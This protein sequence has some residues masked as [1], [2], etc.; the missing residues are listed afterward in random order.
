[1]ISDI[2]SSQG[3]ER[4]HQLILRNIQSIIDPVL[5][6]H[7]LSPLE[8]RERKDLVIELMKHPHALESTK[9]ANEKLLAQ[10]ESME[11][12]MHEIKRVLDEH[13]V[14]RRPTN[15]HFP[16]SKYFD[17][18]FV[19][20]LTD[21]SGEMNDVNAAA[22]RDALFHL[23]DSEKTTH[24]STQKPKIF[25]I[26]FDSGIL[27]IA[28]ANRLTFDW[29]ER[30]VTTVNFHGRWPNAKFN[31]EFVAVKNVIPP[32]GLKT[33]FAK[34]SD[35]QFRHFNYLMK[36]LL[37]DNPN[38]LTGRWELRGLRGIDMDSPNAMYVGVDVES[39]ISLEE[40]NRIAVVG[41]SIVSFHIC[42]DENEEH[43]ELIPRKR[44]I[45]KICF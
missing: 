42:Y 2:R 33:I 20:H 18:P 17:I 11:K 19:V 25:D 28:C 29:I 10:K 16:K 37:L 34:F 35:P 30:T 38:L 3:N 1:M 9:V 12:V 6:P 31:V 4:N 27:V 8:E 22:L 39:L 13:I 45:N 40:N 21:K 26:K 7:Q 32:N 43:F 15:F 44:K 23:I 41:K 36:R 5:Y 24:I 14:V